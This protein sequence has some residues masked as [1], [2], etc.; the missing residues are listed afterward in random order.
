MQNV[1]TA[2]AIGLIAGISGGVI[3]YFIARLLVERLAIVEAPAGV[4]LVILPSGLTA[5]SAGLGFFLAALEGCWTEEH[6]GSMSETAILQ[7]SV[8][9]PAQHRPLAITLKNPAAA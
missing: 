8:T 1:A 4:L 3:G 6:S 7:Q 5:L 9:C 2:A